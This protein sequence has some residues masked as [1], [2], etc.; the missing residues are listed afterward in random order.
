MNKTKIGI[1]MFVIVNKLCSKWMPTKIYIRLLFLLR[2][3]YRLNL[4]N[5]LTY[6]EK[7]QWLKIH[8]RNPEY[9][10]DVDKY[11]VREKIKEHISADILIPIIGIYS[12]PEEIDINE[13]PDQ[14]VIKCTHGTHC[15][16]IC[17]DKNEFDLVKAKQKLRHWMAHNYYYDAREWPYKD[18]IPR[19]VVEK[20]ISDK[21]GE[22]IDYKFMCFDGK[23]KLILVHQDINN[24]QGK[25]TLDIYTPEWELTQIEWGIPKSGK[26]I[27]RPKLLDRCIEIS[28]VLSSG[29][30]HVRVDLYIV[31]EKIYFGELTYYTA[32]GFKPFNSIDDDK[33]IG[34]WISLE[35][36]LRQHERNKL[37]M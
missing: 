10:L 35:R 22:L 31:D 13:M 27:Q 16:I 33:M 2:F 32:A 11:L 17:K 30:P 6:N 21:K 37:G 34:N 5:P 36:I 3:G 29:R 15:S 18:I 7:L 28:E 23:V 4:N 14:F 26:T 12:N 24:T 9:I 25:H 1:Y 20:F 8:D 19:I